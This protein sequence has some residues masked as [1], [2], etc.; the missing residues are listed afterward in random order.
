M[1]NSMS[2]GSPTVGGEADSVG[3]SE[4]G[5]VGPSLLEVLVGSETAQA[6]KLRANNKIVKRIN[7]L[8]FDF[9]I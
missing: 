2:V 4:L 6:T 8:F 3:F 5:E 7:T 9:N 1:K